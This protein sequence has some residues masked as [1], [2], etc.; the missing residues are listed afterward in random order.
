MINGE[1]FPEVTIPEVGRAET[2]VIEVRNLSAAEHPFHLHGQSFE[3]LSIDGVPPNH[4]WVEDTLNVGIRQTL[5][6]QVTNP[7][8]GDWMA[9]CHI[10]G[11][12]E[13]GMMTLL[14]VGETP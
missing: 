9:H 12:A 1:V 11:H 4:R 5:R 7:T 13:Q 14:R 3:V 8:S 6:L 10:L 2:A